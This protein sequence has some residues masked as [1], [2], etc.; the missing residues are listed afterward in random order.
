MNQIDRPQSGAMQVW[1]AMPI[2]AKVITAIVL[3]IALYYSFFFLLGIFVIAAMC[4]GSVTIL[5]WFFQ[6]R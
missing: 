6:R 5:R 3:G 4:V 2:W 1:T